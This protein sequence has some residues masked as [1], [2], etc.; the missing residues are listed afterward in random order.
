MTTTVINFIHQRKVITKGLESNKNYW[1][2]FDLRFTKILNPLDENSEISKY[3]ICGF[4][5]HWTQQC[6]TMSF[7]NRKR[8]KDECKI[9]IIGENIDT[10]IGKTINMAVI[11]TNLE[12]VKKDRSESSFKYGSDRVFKSI[13]CVTLLAV[14]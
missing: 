10:L 14:T 5:Y 13:K 9:T 11:K 4:I 1:P 6:P 8:S 2:V 3:K 12:A 7:E